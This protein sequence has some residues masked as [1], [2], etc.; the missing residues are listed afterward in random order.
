MKLSAMFI[1]VASLNVIA[2]P[3]AHDDSIQRRANF[4]R[5]LTDASVDFDVTEKRTSSK[6]PL[7]D[8]GIDFAVAEKRASPENL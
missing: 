3:L 4:K 5:T 1:L 7:M 8:A 6:P 2:V